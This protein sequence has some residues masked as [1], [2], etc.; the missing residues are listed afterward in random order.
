MKMF[1][2]TLAAASKKAGV[3][4]ELGRIPGAPHT[5][6]REPKPRDLRPRV[7]ALLDPYLGSAAAAAT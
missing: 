1:A 3:P 2:K 7:L 5:P 4:H 6:D